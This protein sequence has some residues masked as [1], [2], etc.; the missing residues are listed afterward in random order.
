MENP[1]HAR[2]CNNCGA[3]LVAPELQPQTTTPPQTFRSR[4]GESDLMESELR[5]RSGPVIVSGLLV[6][7]VALCGGA[8]LFAMNVVSP[9]APNEPDPA[10]EMIQQQVIPAENATLTTN[11]PRPTVPFATVT[12]APPT[13]TPTPT[14]GPCLITVQ[15][16]ATLYG[17]LA[18]CGHRDFDVLDEVLEINDLADGTSLQLGDVIEVPRPTPTLDPNATE[19][20]GDDSDGAV[21]GEASGGGFA[22]ILL[23]EGVEDLPTFTPS[24]SPT[25]PPGVMWHLIEPNQDI[26]TIA[27]LYSSGVE[28]LSQLNPEIDFAQCDFGE[29]TGG[30]DCTVFLRA[31]QQ[32]RVP[33]P[34]P[35]PTL[36][37]SPSGSETATPTATATFNAPILTSP[38]SGALFR[39]DEL[40]TLRWAG[41]GTLGEDEVYRVEIRNLTV[42]VEYTQDVRDPLFILP[43]DWQQLDGRRHEYR[44]RILIIDR[45]NPTEPK[46]QTPFRT[47]TWE[48]TGERATEVNEE[49]ANS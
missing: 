18:L 25:L 35:T 10:V 1:P 44:W 32:M 24:P 14:E 30:P 38:G 19:E 9:G 43:S 4:F 37:P 20:A 7:L 15:S 22:S 45:S 2:F 17:I 40:V 42:D 31:G 13:V 11:T 27:Y 23:A 48:A 47:F 8:T 16:G 5:W 34:T 33:A 28:V 29:F 46:F 12:N 49:D 26:T 36:E 39:R 41:T 21:E 3:A 6:L